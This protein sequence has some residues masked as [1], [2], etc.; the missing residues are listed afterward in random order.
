LLAGDLD[1]ADLRFRDGYDRL[2]AIG[3]KNRRSTLAAQLGHIAARR[4]DPEAAERY[5]REAIEVA[6]PSDEDT[7]SIVAQARSHLA[8]AAGDLAGAVE[9][10]ELAVRTLEGRGATWQQAEYFQLLGD[11]RIAAGDRDGGRAAL[12]EALARFEEKQIL[13]RIDEVRRRLDDLA[14]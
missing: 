3:E 12:E 9:Q 10:A 13:P 2:R 8:T 11:A 7:H 6:S 14:T 4:G 1:A 5:L